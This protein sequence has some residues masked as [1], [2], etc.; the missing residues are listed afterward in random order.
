ML[1][2]K[3]APFDIRQRK[4]PARQWGAKRVYVEHETALASNCVPQILERTKIV[5]AQL[6][7]FLHATTAAGRNCAAEMSH[8]RHMYICILSNTFQNARGTY[9]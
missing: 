9:R 2:R 6:W 3:L 4:R 5:D 7:S 1:L 8:R